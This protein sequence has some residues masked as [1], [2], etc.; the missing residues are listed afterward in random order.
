MKET[1][2]GFLCQIL[3]THK[4]FKSKILRELIVTF[5]SLGDVLLPSQKISLRVLIENSR[6]FFFFL[7]VST[8]MEWSMKIRGF[9][10]KIECK[11]KWVHLTKAHYLSSDRKNEEKI[12]FWNKTLGLGIKPSDLNAWTQCA[13]Y[14][15]THTII[16]ALWLR[17]FA[18]A[19]NNEGVMVYANERSVGL[20]IPRH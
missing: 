6:D 12:Y 16:P 20:T 2:H 11:K 10:S 13:W 5:Y 9:K 3:R 15:R 17:K 1:L 8:S 18:Y 19:K 7:S 4:S 14:W